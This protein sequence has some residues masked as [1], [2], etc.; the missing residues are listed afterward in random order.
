M[1]ST[2]PNSWHCY[3]LEPWTAAKV[4]SWVEHFFLGEYLKSSCFVA[5]ILCGLFCRFQMH[6]FSSCQ[7]NELCWVDFKKF[8]QLDLYSAGNIYKQSPPIVYWLCV[9][10]T[11]SSFCYWVTTDSSGFWA[12]NARKN[13][14]NLQQRNL[15]NNREKNLF[16]VWSILVKKSFLCKFC[17]KGKSFVKQFVKE[18]RKIV[19][20]N[21]VP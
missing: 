11:H 12:R 13:T 1:V 5:A 17:K 8:L 10:Y 15:L 14:T 16:C 4:I 9:T 18:D 7:P 20:V 21:S 6:P 3:C 2:I 19:Q